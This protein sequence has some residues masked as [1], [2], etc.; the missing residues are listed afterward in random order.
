MLAKHLKGSLNSQ[1]KISKW[2]QNDVLKF[3]KWP[4]DHRLNFSK[5]LFN[6]YG[7]SPREWPTTFSKLQTF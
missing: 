2:L 1:Q 7:K 6:K 5:G 3:L 4:L